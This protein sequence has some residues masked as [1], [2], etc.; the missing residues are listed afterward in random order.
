MS[1]P[2]AYLHG[3]HREGSGLR[4]ERIAGGADFIGNK[5]ALLVEGEP[6]FTY[7]IL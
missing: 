7:E 4:R 5:D 1:K 3:L 6:I 2:L